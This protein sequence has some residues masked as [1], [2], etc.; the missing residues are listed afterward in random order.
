MDISTNDVMRK[1]VNVIGIIQGAIEPGDY[2]GVSR[3]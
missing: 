3:V 2:C 1:T